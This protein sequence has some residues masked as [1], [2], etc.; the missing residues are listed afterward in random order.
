MPR[1]TYSTTLFNNNTTCNNKILIHLLFIF[2]F[3]YLC[4][5]IK[6]TSS[7]DG[8]VMIKINEW[9]VMHGDGGYKM[10]NNITTCCDGII[11]KRMLMTF[12]I[13]RIPHTMCLISTPEWLS[14]TLGW[15]FMFIRGEHYTSGM[16]SFPQKSHLG[17][18]NCMWSWVVELVL[19]VG[20][21]IWS[22]NVYV[23]RWF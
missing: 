14:I 18:E 12:L 16:G 1:C 20:D 4:T 19:I 17:G 13:W 2:Y 7:G 21:I 8:W 10:I 3:V 15:W 11:V 23:V 6:W 5:T 9:I 22:G